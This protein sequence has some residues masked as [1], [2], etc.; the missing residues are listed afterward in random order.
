MLRRR[1]AVDRMTWPKALPY[2][3]AALIARLTG[4][5]GPCL[6][7]ST[8]CASRTTAIGEGARLIREGICDTVLAG[9]AE[10]PVTALSLAGFSRMGSLSTRNEAPALASR[11]FDA[12]RDGYV[13]G[14]GAAFLHLERWDLAA[15]R[16]APVLAEISGYAQTCDA[17]HITAPRPDGSVAADCIRRALA[18]SGHAPH[19]IGHVNCHCTATELNDPMEARALRAV[20]DGRPPPV[21]APKSVLGHLLGAA[22]AAEAVVAVLAAHHG[23]VPPVANRDRTAPD[24]P[25]DVV[26]GAPRPLGRLPVVSTSFG[27]GGHNA[28]P[29]VTPSTTE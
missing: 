16:G 9:A 4:R 20:F 21:T 7:V 25:L 1:A 19:E 2:A 23:L 13:I 18:D 15:A 17:H 14:E 10:A 12:D 3:A 22:E 26:A 5:Q 6:T 8:A 29:V 28:C 24:G 11:P 27:F